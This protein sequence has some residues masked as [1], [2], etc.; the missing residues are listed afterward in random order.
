ML[1]KIVPKLSAFLAPH[2][3]DL[4]QFHIWSKQYTSP[5]IHL[6]LPKHISTQNNLYCFTKAHSFKFL[7]KE[8]WGPCTTTQCIRR[9]GY[10]HALEENRVSYDIIV[11]VPK[12]CG[13]DF[14]RENA[15]LLSV[16][17][18]QLRA[19]CFLNRSHRWQGEVS[20]LSLH[21]L[22]NPWG[23]THIC[24]YVF[25]W[26]LFKRQE[27][28]APASNSMAVNLPL[29][30]KPAGQWA[31]GYRANDDVGAAGYIYRKHACSNSPLD[32]CLN[33]NLILDV[34]KPVHAIATS[35]C[36]AVEASFRQ[37]CFQYTH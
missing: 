34:L 17:L 3:T 20:Y 21:L 18:F 35:H 26:H 5:F 7:C 14:P 1:F 2:L 37:W 36:A 16:P 11:W 15:Q 10:R 33:T 28:S 30:F 25:Y 24:W 29:A 9:P 32:I 13:K 4:F 19:P 22:P 12:S 8:K 31:R 27:C 23:E 6:H